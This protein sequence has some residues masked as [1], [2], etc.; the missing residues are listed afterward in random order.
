MVATAVVSAVSSALMGLLANYPFGLAPGM[1]MNAY[2]VFTVVLQKQVEW[3][4]ALTAVFFSG[5][6]FLITTILG[7]R[8]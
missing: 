6:L 3:Q 7:L 8:R 1:G 4:D 2:F 5:W